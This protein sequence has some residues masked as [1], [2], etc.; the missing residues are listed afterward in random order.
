MYAYVKNILVF[1]HAG[2]VHL[3]PFSHRDGHY[4]YFD[5]A[6]GCVVGFPTTEVEVLYIAPSLADARRQ[7]AA[8]GLVIHPPSF[9]EIP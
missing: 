4:L 5:L 1:R 2:E 7:A 3:L 8:A 9:A 6:N